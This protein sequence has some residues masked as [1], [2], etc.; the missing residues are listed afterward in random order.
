MDL[1]LHPTMHIAHHNFDPGLTYFD[2]KDPPEL[3][4]K[5]KFKNVNYANYWETTKAVEYLWQAS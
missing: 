1:Q 5:H 4:Y 2:E 3:T